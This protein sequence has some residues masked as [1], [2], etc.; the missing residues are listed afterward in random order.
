MESVASAGDFPVLA[1]RRGGF[2][3]AGIPDE[4][5]GYDAAVALVYADLAETVLHTFTGSDGLWPAGSLIRDSEGNLYGTT[6]NGGTAEGGE[7]HSW[8]R[9]GVQGG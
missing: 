9:H 2:E 8:L 6:T 7:V 4:R 5:H 1:L 3:Q